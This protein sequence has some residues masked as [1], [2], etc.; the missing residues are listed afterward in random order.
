MLQHKSIFK[1]NH[2]FELR[3][4]ESSRVLYKYPGRI[5]I[6]CEKNAK[7]TDIVNLD[8]NKYLVP[9]DLNCGQFIYTIRQRLKLPAE[10]GIFLSING[11]TP[12]VTDTIGNLYE[13]YKDQDN[14]LYVTYAS[15]NVFG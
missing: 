4:Q 10:K 5:P 9:I 2:S 12:S 3:Y 1:T 8:K 6:I 14:F 11:I 15:E 13:K 7:N